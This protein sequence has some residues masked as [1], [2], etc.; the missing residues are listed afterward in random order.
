VVG[1]CKH[2]DICL[3]SSNEGISIT[4][5]EIIEEALYH[6]FC[7]GY[8]KACCPRMSIKLTSVLGI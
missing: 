4:C 1:I 5:S 2:G 8:A 7:Q 6:T 3:G